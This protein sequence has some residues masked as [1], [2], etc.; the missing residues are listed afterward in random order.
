MKLDGRR[1]IAPNLHNLSV[2][3]IEDDEFKRK[4]IAQV[5][6]E[7]M[8]HS[9]LILERAVNSGL[10]AIVEKSPDLILLDMSLTTFDVGPNEPGGRP[11]NF[12]GM[13]VLRQ[14]DRLS[15]VIPTIVITQHERF[16]AGG[17]EVNL[18]SLYKE[19]VEEHEKV[20]RGLIYYNSARGG[21]EQ[22][23]RSFV[24][25]IINDMTQRR[26]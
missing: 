16:V 6:S 26:R 15:I 3:V 12:G 7:I 1:E 2:L 10:K 25:P 22:E 21:W 5:I 24:N 13:E 9:I 23:L 8:P 19:L 14:M 11:Q 4:R 18:S 20:F 17:E